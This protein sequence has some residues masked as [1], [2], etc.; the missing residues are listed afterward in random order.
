MYPR[1]YQKGEFAWSIYDN[2]GQKS[3]MNERIGA[4]AEYRLAPMESD[5]QDYQ[6][7]DGWKEHQGLEE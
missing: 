1:L 6:G 3:R 5:E 2:V 7:A 4:L